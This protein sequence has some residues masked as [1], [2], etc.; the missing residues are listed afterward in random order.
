MAVALLPRIIVARRVRGDD[1][2]LLH[3]ADTFSNRGLARTRRNPS[4]HSP[5]CLAQC[6]L[7]R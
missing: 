2:L 3:C 7:R 1:D 4:Q 6:C 5:D